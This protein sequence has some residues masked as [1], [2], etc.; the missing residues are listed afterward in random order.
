MVGEVY[1]TIGAA[2]EAGQIWSHL[3][4]GSRR[5]V[6]ITRNTGRLII[7]L[8]EEAASILRNAEEILAGAWN[9]YD[10]HVTYFISERGEPVQRPE[11]VEDQDTRLDTGD[12][13]DF[14]GNMREQFKA[15]LTR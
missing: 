14:G 6:D 12:E 8:P 4:T 1:S 7:G 3:V 10:L 2:S 11:L 13:L 5:I 15:F 9:S